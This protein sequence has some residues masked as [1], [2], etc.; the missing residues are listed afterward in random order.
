M[1][2]Y[3]YHF[4]LRSYS[5]A[6]IFH[7]SYLLGDCDKHHAIPLCEALRKGKIISELCSPALTLGLTRD[8]EIP[9]APSKAYG[10]PAHKNTNNSSALF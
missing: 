4:H 9:A 3:Q 2:R 5:S 6:R 10:L 1:A 7:L 8:L